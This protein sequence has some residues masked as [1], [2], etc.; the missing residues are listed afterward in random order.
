[1]PS[2]SRND[3]ADLKNHRVPNN[4]NFF[5]FRLI[6]HFKIFFLLLSLPSSVRRFSCPT[7]GGVILPGGGTFWGGG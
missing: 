5:I 3:I 1:M 4:V 7:G 6:F 2:L